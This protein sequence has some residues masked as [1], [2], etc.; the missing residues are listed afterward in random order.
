MELK[1]LHNTHEIVNKIVNKSYWPPRWDPEKHDE[2]SN[3][4]GLVEVR[5]NEEG[6]LEPIEGW[7]LALDDNVKG[8]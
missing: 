4:C 6:E 7:D 1:D 2:A 5:I 8:G 3:C